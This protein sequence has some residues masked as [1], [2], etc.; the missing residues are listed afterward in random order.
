MAQ[1]GDRRGLAFAV[2]VVVVAAVGIYLTIGPPSEEQ[3]EPA[4]EATPAAVTPAASS[5]P[6]A[7]ASAE[8]FDVYS[9]LP[10]QKEQLAAAA[11]LAER[12]TAEYGT[13]RHDEDPAA[14]AA[15]LKA[16][17]TAEFGNELTRTLS[18]AGTIE[19][20][21]NDEIV[22]T[23]TARLKE[24]RQVEKTSVVFV[25]SATRQVAAKSGAKQHNEEYAVT[26]SQVGA[27]WRVFDL[28]PSTEG[29]EGD[30]LE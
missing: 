11:D 28:R 2:I 3:A 4:R 20:N 9:Y 7:T 15:R 23:A 27:D 30:I 6:L 24:I 10:M 25:I 29:Q 19:Q 13:F 18:S 14:Y 26:V 21:R 22:S 16:Y 1:P 5:T 17:T 12:F 8:P